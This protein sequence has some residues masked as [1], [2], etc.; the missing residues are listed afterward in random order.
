MP[1]PLPASCSPG[2]PAE[3][4]CRQAPPSDYWS[5]HEGG[6]LPGTRL[7]GTRASAMTLCH[8]HTCAEARAQTRVGSTLVRSKSSTFDCRL[9]AKAYV[10]GYAQRARRGTRSAASPMQQYIMCCC[11]MEAHRAQAHGRRDTA[12]GSPLDHCRCQPNVL[13]H[14]RRHSCLGRNPHTCASQTHRR[15][16]TAA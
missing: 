11:A 13:Q 5:S 1:T 12:A 4:A 2:D 8:H 16:S 9:P 10:R 6:V 3:V 7:K 14:A 15:R